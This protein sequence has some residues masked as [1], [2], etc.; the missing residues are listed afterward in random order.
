MLLMLPPSC[1]YAFDFVTAIFASRHAITL[2]PPCRHW[3]IDTI[4]MLAMLLLP[5]ADDAYAAF[6]QRHAAFRYAFAAADYFA[7][8]RYADAATPLD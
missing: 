1:R 4:S 2:M 5:C 8:L 6:R 7:T 3:L